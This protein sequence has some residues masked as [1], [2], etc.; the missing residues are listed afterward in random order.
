MAVLRAL[1][2]EFISFWR[3]VLTLTQNALISGFANKANHAMK[4]IFYKTKLSRFPTTVA[5]GGKD[6][7]DPVAYIIDVLVSA[8]AQ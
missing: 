1:E 6:S 4:E 7:L 3:S 2:A 8:N 5:L